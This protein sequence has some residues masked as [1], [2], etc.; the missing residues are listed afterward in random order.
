[1]GLLA[2]GDTFII[3]KICEKRYSSNRTV[4][5]IASVLF[6]VMPITWLTRRV[7]LDSIMLLCFCYP[8]YLLCTRQLIR[9]SSLSYEGAE[10]IKTQD[11]STCNSF[12]NPTRTCDLYKSSCA[13]DDTIGRLSNI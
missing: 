5:F 10:T 4:A 11:S 8:Y 2:I 12:R 7:L 3:Y 1:M 9:T 13:Y 6:A